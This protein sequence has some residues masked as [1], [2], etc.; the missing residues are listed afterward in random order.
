MVT[1]DA[2]TKIIMSLVKAVGDYSDVGM[3]AQ[4]FSWF[5]TGDTEWAVQ[6]VPPN[7]PIAAF[8]IAHIE[9]AERQGVDFSTMT[10]EMM[11][12]MFEPAEN[13]CRR[14]GMMFAALTRD[15]GQRTKVEIIN[16]ATMDIIT[17][18]VGAYDRH[19][20][21]EPGQQATEQRFAAT[22]TAD[23]ENDYSYRNLVEPPPAETLII[24]PLTNDIPIPDR[25]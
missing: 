9:A 24:A 20:F 10:F 15:T 5:K 23:I 2:Y 19:H 14:V 1:L 25:R 11:L 18:S 8:T 22:W 3:P 21:S 13:V 12:C 17:H 6:Q 4:P 7:T 16:D